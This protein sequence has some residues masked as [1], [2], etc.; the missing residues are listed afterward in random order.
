VESS[1]GGEHRISH[2][3]IR[4]HRDIIANAHEREALRW[5]EF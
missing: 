5:S 3:H 4:R 1:A 2:R